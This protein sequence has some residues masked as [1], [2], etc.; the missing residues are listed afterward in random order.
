MKRTYKI[1]Q[2]LSFFSCLAFLCA[3]GQPKENSPYPIIDW[4]GYAS[5]AI[6]ISDYVDSISYIQFDS[7]VVIPGFACVHATDS[8]FFLGTSEGILKYSH[9]G[10][11][12]RKIGNIGQGPGEY[13]R[14]QNKFSLDTRNQQVYVYNYPDKIMA[15]TFDGEYL[16]Q[17]KIEKTE[18]DCIPAG[19]HF[20]NGYFYFF[21]FFYGGEDQPY[22]WEII[23]ANGKTRSFK[24]DY[25]T[26]WENDEQILPFHGGFISYIWQNNSALYW[27]HVNDTIYRVSENKQEPAYLWAKNPLRLS[28]E[29]VENT[30]FLSPYRIIETN[31]Y[32]FIQ[33]F[34]NWNDRLPNGGFTLDIHNCIYDKRNKTLIGAKDNYFTDDINGGCLGGI[35]H[36]VVIQEKEYI[37]AIVLPENLTEALMKTNTP[38]SRTLAANIDEEGKPV[39]VLM[40]IKKN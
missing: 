13:I 4:E 5:G 2:V 15:F 3:C 6:Q 23:D 20:I 32:L 27:N 26:R 40:R 25:N 17:V 7:A 19:F 10:K 21:Y 29:Y 38:K 30:K 1:V 12:L 31:D 37:G 22:L 36:Y 14:G 35:H 28:K 34:V 18:I 24:R 39:L 9:R 16:G 11:F 8:F 33:W